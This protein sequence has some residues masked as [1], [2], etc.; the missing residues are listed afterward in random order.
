VRSAFI[1]FVAIGVLTAPGG[2]AVAQQPVAA[3]PAYS[4]PP[5]TS[6]LLDGPDLAQAQRYCLTCHSADYVTTQPRGMP[7][8]FWDGEI[9]KMRTA[10]GATIPDDQAKLI[11]NYLTIAY[12]APPPR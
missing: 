5:E 7:Q 6:R 11:A 8:A 2:L 3:P 10:Y 9:A 4:P 1:P 12:A